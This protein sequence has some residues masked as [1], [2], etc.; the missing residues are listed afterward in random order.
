MATRM[1][2][3]SH[4]IIE[5]P[6]TPIKQLG[7]HLNNFTAISQMFES[8]QEGNQPLNITARMFKQS[9]GQ[10]SILEILSNT[11]RPI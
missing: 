10:V 5:Y 11:P 1:F 8:L 7:N 6:T 9:H 2:E 3:Q 4:G